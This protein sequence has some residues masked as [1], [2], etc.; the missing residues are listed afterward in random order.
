MK[1]IFFIMLISLVFLFV[2]NANAKMYECTYKN[3][4]GVN[5]LNPKN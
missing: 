1:K 2:E 3:K 5:E 4:N